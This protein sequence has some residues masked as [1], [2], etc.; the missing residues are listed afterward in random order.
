LTTN[1][2]VLEVKNISFKTKTSKYCKGKK[3]NLN[4]EQTYLNQF[5]ATHHPL[6]Y[7]KELLLV[8]DVRPTAD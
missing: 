4:S 5:C 7:E 1:C 3:E 6:T 2:N 8:D